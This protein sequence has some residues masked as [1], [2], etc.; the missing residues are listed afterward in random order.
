MNELFTT[1]RQLL[2]KHLKKEY[3]EELFDAMAIAVMGLL[4]IKPELTLEKFPAILEEL[5]II[6][7]GGPILD[8]AINNIKDYV[9]DGSLDYSDAAVIRGLSIDEVDDG[10]QAKENR[11]FILSMTN[12]HHEPALLVSKITHEFIH[13]LR[14]GGIENKNGK[15]KIYAGVNTNYFSVEHKTMNRKHVILE[16][17]IVQSYTNLAMEKLTKLLENEVLEKGSFLSQY[18]DDLLQFSDSSYILPTRIIDC[19]SEDSSFHQLIDESFENHSTPSAVSTYFN[20]VMGS[21]NAFT[22]FSKQ[23]DFCYYH[24]LDDDCLSKKAVSSLAA[25]CSQFRHLTK[26]NQKKK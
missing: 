1:S 16:E 22:T 5:P 6:A 24:D 19:L 7:E 2:Q 25:T 20:S 3:P 12:L 13:L 18:R 15:L 17:G 23:L 9:D 26:T 14:F 21:A 11:I 10:I 4:L 8:I